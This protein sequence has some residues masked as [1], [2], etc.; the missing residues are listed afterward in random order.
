MR[1]HPLNLHQPSIK[2]K[3]KENELKQ[4]IESMISMMSYDVIIL[5]TDY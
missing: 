2:M 5:I 4:N 3:R 1:P